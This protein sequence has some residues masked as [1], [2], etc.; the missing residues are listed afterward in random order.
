M[1]GPRL[2][3]VSGSTQPP[4]R[5]G[6]ER[7]FL[8]NIP[9]GGSRNQKTIWDAGQDAL[10]PTCVVALRWKALAPDDIS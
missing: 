7:Q 10:L 9:Q 8:L 4:A 2:G 6:D 3:R 1:V 5:T